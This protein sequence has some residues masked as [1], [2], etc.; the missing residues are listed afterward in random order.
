MAQYINKDTYVENT[1]K[2]L[3]DIK[4]DVVIIMADGLSGIKYIK[5]NKREE[6]WK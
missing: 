1:G 2:Q 4:T 3:K 6:I 5:Y